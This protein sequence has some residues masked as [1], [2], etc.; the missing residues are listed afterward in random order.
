MALKAKQLG[1]IQ[2]LGALVAGWFG[3]QAQRWD[4]VV[5]AAVFLVMSYHHLT[6]RK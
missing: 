1:W 2:L 3:W 5:L 6:E 4:S